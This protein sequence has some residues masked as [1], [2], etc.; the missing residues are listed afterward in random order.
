M[1]AY[2]IRRILIGLMILVL[3]SMAVFLLFDLLP[4]D[5][6]ALTCGKNCTPEIIEINRVR[7]GLDLPLWQQYIEFVKGLFAGRTYGSGTAAFTCAAPCLGYSFR[8]GEEVTPLILEALPVT[9]YLAVGAFVV[10]ITAGVLLGIFAALRRGRWQEKVT[11]GGAL[12][13]YSF[14][15]FFIGLLLLFFVVIRWRLLPYPSYVP[16]TEDPVR[17][18]QTMILPWITLALVFAAFYIRL[19]RNQMLETLSEDYIRTARSKGLPE[20]T[21]IGKHGLRAGLTPIVTAAG[22]DLAGLLGGAI[23]VE[24]VFSLPGLGRLAIT[25]VLDSDLSIIVATVL[26]AGSF[27]VIA[28]I[29]VDLLYAVIDPRVRLT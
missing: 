22:L 28:N 1:T 27:I 14:P 26:V 12:V 15:S 20:R 25:S 3:L 17:F 24:S 7:L 16:P 4:A 8:K 19:T 18:L 23:I 29:V 13:G 10:W 2:V 5:P 11:L 9:I 6:A 21:V